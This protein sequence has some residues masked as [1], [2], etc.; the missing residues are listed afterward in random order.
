MKIFN[1][2][3]NKPHGLPSEQDENFVWLVYY[4]EDG[5]YDGS[6]EAVAL[7]ADGRL[8]LLNLS[9]CS[10]YEPFEDWMN[11]QFVSIEEYLR[12]KDSVHDIEVKNVVDIKVRELLGK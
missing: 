2:G 6:G 10:C 11:G 12:P 7:M 4:Y 9:H 8:Q 1:V 3:D 5:Y